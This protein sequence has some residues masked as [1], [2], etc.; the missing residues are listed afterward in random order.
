[1]NNNWLFSVYFFF[2]FVWYEHVCAEEQADERCRHTTS[3]LL[4]ILRQDLS[5]PRDYLFTSFT[6]Q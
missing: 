5:E 2:P 6:G 4:Y 3:S 1:M